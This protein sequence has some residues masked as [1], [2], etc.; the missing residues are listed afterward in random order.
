MSDSKESPLVSDRLKDAQEK[1][2]AAA[3]AVREVSYAI[4]AGAGHYWPGDAPTLNVHWHS[5]DKVPP[6]GLTW[7][8][9]GEAVWIIHS[10]GKPIGASATAVRFWTQACIPAPPNRVIDHAE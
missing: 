1:L 10:D 7:A 2:V 3:M 9:N 6:A 8:S 5:R 4:R